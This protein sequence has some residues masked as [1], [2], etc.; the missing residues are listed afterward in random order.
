MNQFFKNFPAFV[1]VGISF[2]SGISAQAQEVKNDAKGS[3]GSGHAKAAL[4]IGCHSIEG[5]NASF[6]EVHKVPKIAG[7]GPKYIVSALNAYKKGERKHPTMRGIAAAL[8][9]QDIVDVAAFYANSGA[10]DGVRGCG[11]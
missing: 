11:V 4:C 10:I 1:I 2:F 6:P 5:Y 8:S 9:D 7:Q 3:V